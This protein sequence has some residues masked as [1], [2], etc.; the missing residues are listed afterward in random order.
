MR[1]MDDFVRAAI[2]A[3]VD[4]EEAMVERMLT[5]PRGWGVLEHDYGLRWTLELSPRVPLYEIHVHK[6]A[7][8]T[9]CAACDRYE[10]DPITGVIGPNVQP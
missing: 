2:E 10:S 1:T 9:S 4:A 6:V 7:E 5:D 3:R 8:G